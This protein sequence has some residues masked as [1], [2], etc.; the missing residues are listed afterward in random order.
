MT[1]AT[2]ARK[3]KRWALGARS[4]K[5]DRKFRNCTYWQHRR[6]PTKQIR[7]VITQKHWNVRNKSKACRVANTLVVSIQT[8]YLAGLWICLQK[9][10]PHL[11]LGPSV[12][13]S[14]NLQLPLS[15]HVFAQLPSIHSIGKWGRGQQTSRSR[16]WSRCSLMQLVT[17]PLGR[18]K[19]PGP[20][21]RKTCLCLPVYSCIYPYGLDLSDFRSGLPF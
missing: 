21:C 14:Q 4:M 7:I 11:V 12:R 6:Y 15:T 18:T 10:S 19:P 20:G 9:H 8:K 1:Q 16:K 2:C 17:S 13:S 5:H 3:K